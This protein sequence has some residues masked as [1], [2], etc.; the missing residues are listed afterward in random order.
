M[1]AKDSFDPIA[2]ARRLLRAG[3]PAALATLTPA[4]G[5]PSCS[6]VN[7]AS[8]ADGSPL[9]LL[10]D[11]AVH[12]KNLAADARASLL[13][14]D[15]ATGDPLA[16]PR[17]S[18]G[19]RCERLPPGPAEAAHR[20]RYLARHPST[21]GYAAFADFALYRMTLTG[22]HL[23]AGFGR[24][25]GLTPQQILTDLTDAAELVD[26]EAGAVAH[27]N[28]DHAD[29]V[30]LFATKLLGA[31]EGRWRMT[32]IDPDGCDLAHDGQVRRLDFPQRVTTAQHLRQTLVALTAAA[33]T[34]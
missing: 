25:V 21:A 30:A 18:L 31:A 33:R 2:E 28:E 19:G 7:V 5:A 11:L 3:G 26:A 12:A 34:R 24:I 27:M 32:G 1:D 29:A 13:L 16:A 17:I 22:G 23:V 20:A 10:S 8:A 4:D 14:A 15:A 9:L 6:L